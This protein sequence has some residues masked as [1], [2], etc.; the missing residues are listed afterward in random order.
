MTRES[1]QAPAPASTTPRTHHASHGVPDE[2]GHDPYR[3]AGKLPEPT[4]CPDCH[5]VFQRGRWHWNDTL[6]GATPHRCPACRRIREHL[7]AGIVTL[8]GPFLNAHR[9]D[10]MACVRRICDRA[11]VEH[12]LERV[13]E[14]DEDDAEIR[15]STTSSHLARAIG[16]ALHEAWDG[17]LE[18]DPH[19]QGMPRVAWHRP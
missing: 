14:I 1:P 18:L 17:Q 16:R 6:P 19:A 15:V 7:P 5:A 9:D 11:Y 12:P 4:V 3:E 8:S 13:M 2:E 10:I